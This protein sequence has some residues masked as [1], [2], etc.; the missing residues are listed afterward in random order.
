MDL[1]TLN[2]KGYLNDAFFDYDKSDLRDDARSALAADAEWLKKHASGPGPDRGPLRRARH[3]RVQPRAR[4]PPRQRRQGVPRL[5]RHRRVAHPDGLLRQGAPL[6]HRVRRR[7]AGRRTAAPT[8]SSRPSEP[9]GS[10]R[11]PALLGLSSAALLAGAAC[12]SSS[13][14]D[15]LHRQMNDI[16]K[17]IQALERKSS[18]KEEV[19]KLNQNV[20]AQTQ[21]LLKSQRRHGRQAGRADD[22]DGAAR[23]QA[24]GHEPP[25]LAALAADRRDAG[26]PAPPAQ[27]GRRSRRRARRAGRRR[28]G[29][30]TAAT[31]SRPPARRTVA[32]PSSTTPPTP[33][34]R[35][36]A[37]P[38][39]SRA[40]RTTCEPIP[41][42]ISPTTPSTGS[43]SRTTRRR[44]TPRRSPTSTS[45]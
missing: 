22:E 18:S 25:P 20:A 42:P 1:E 38:S 13:D 30:P 37:T 29:A 35:R 40:S 36:G 39:R 41:T 6:L 12:V 28:P 3:R 14:I 15:G 7:A 2:K 8:S 11:R 5:A 32:R 31:G 10:L 34:T 17:Q 45:S 24:R 23:G 21:Q 9:F 33:T 43:A 27:R 19:A 44:S 26:R 16:E 4:R